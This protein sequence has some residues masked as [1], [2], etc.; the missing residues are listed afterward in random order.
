M[1][2]KL[3]TLDV[4]VVVCLLFSDARR[5]TSHRAPQECRT[6]LPTASEIHGAF[7]G[8][9]LRLLARDTF[10]VWSVPGLVGFLLQSQSKQ[11]VF[12][13]SDVPGLP[14]RSEFQRNVRICYGVPRMSPLVL[15]RFSVPRAV[16]CNTV[17]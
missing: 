14:G 10:Q 11:V 15:L 7:P 12:L 8:D 6:E 2:K 16:R 3:K 9:L 5:L 4:R 1:V 13:W 17:L